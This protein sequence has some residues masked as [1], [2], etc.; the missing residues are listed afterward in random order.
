MPNTVSCGGNGGIVY[1]VG[2]SGWKFQFTLPQHATW[3]SARRPQAKL[4][5]TVMVVKRSGG[6]EDW[7]DP[8]SP[9]H[10]ALPSGRRPQVLK[11]PALIAVNSSAGGVAWPAQLS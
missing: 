8:F 6:G 1:G 11:E 5:P 10:S 4:S 2:G 7:P 3:P 9:Q